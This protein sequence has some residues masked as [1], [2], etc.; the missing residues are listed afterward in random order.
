MSARAEVQRIDHTGSTWFAA[1]LLTVSLPITGLLV[2]GWRPH[3]LPPTA[4]VA[5]WIGIVMIGIGIA[6]IG[7]AG[8]PIYW[9][10][11]ETAHLQ[12]SIAI[13]GG[14]VSFLL[15]CFI[16]VVALLAS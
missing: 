14:L 16:A 8:C 11:V 12:K 4:G 1:T 15:G 3:D 10:N 5:W 6:A 2:S 13:R 9:G 7:Y